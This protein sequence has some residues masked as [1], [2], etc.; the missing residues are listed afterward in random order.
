MND[1]WTKKAVETFPIV[2]NSGYEALVGHLLMLL[3]VK[4]TQ[5]EWCTKERDALS[6]QLCSEATRRDVLY[7]LLS[8]W[9]HNYRFL[10]AGCDE[11]RDSV[12]KT[13]NILDTIA[14]DVYRPK[15]D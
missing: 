2:E 12:V 15:R 4:S 5:L 7:D 13:K 6:T 14:N 1:K 9:L 8:E 11:E 10:V 3:D